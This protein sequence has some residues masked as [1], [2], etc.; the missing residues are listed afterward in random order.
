VDPPFRSL[1]MLYAVGDLDGDGAGDVVTQSSFWQ[2]YVVVGDDLLS[3]GA[4]PLL[5]SHYGLPGGN[6]PAPLR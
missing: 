4:A 6:A 5:S 1:E 3:S 2:E